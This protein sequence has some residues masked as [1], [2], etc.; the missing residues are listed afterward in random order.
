VFCRNSLVAVF[1]TLLA[2]GE[3]HGALINYDEG[4]GDLDA[5]F[6]TLFT[7]DMAGSHS[8]MGSASIFISEAGE[9][10]SDIDSD[11]FQ[12][13][14]PSGFAITTIDF[15]ISGV[16]TSEYTVEQTAAI[17]VFGPSSD[18]SLVFSTEEEVFNQMA[19]HN[20]SPADELPIGA[21]TYYVSTA[22]LHTGCELLGEPC[23]ASWDWSL[24]MTAVE[25]DVDDHS[26]VPLP[27]PLSLIVLGLFALGYTKYKCAS[28]PL[29]TMR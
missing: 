15:S 16:E 12:L 1:M 10:N 29:L 21:G 14:L 19:D 7:V 6:T 2:L 11:S 27:S 20:A 28:R 13:L 18:P 9:S 3:A 23:N 26:P 4:A 24:T 5:A 17:S 22:T 25:V 8:W